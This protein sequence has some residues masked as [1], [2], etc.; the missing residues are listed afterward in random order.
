M[1]TNWT[2]QYFKNIRDLHKKISKDFNKFYKSEFVQELGKLSFF[3]ISYGLS[4][5]FALFALG[6]IGFNLLTVLGCG[7]LWYFISEEGPIVFMKYKLG[8]R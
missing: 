4:F 8:V 6:L 2:N 7:F 3:I 1:T 5:N